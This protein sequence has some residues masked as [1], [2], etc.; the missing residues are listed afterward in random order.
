MSG[1]KKSMIL[2][3]DVN[4]YRPLLDAV[5]AMATKYEQHISTFKGYVDKPGGTAWEGQTAE[6]SQHNVG[7]GWKVTARIQDLDTKY[8]TTAGLAV[9]HTIVP[10]LSNCQHMI[11]NIEA[12]RNKGLTLSEDLEVGYNPPPGISEQLAA[13]NAKVAKARGEELKESARKWWEAEQEVKRL[14]EGVIRDI[15]NEVNSAAGTFDIGKAVK[16][17]A[18]RKPE[19]TQD[20]NFYKDWYPKKD[21]PASTQAAA[22]TA[23][24]PH[25]PVLGPPLPGDKPPVDPSKLGGLTGNLGVM[26]ITDPKSPLDKPPS[27]PDARTAPAPKLDPN[28]PQGKAAIDKFRGILATQYPPDQVEAKL[29]DA[30]K[31]AQ[32]DRPMVATP[33]P[34]TPER[35]RQSGGEAFAESWDQAGRAKDDLLGINGGDHAKE[36]WKGVAKGLWDV[37]NPDPVHQVEHGI[38]QAKGAIDEVKSGIDNPKA[39]IGKHGIEIAA[40]IATAPLGGEGALLG[41]E[42]RALTH[43]L[44]DAAP[45]H[46]PT[47]HSVE[48]PSSATHA[49]IS[50]HPA[51]ANADHSSVTP[52]ADGPRLDMEGNPLKY[53]NG[54]RPDYG[55]N[56]LIDVWGLSREEQIADIR[57]GK[58]DLPEP[59]P[60][61]QWVRLHPTGPIGD[62]WTVE[63]GHRLIEWQDGDSRTGLWDMGHVGGNEYAK[64]RDQYHDG[65][66]TFRDFIDEYRDP[67]NY[68]VQDPYR[69]RSH[70]DEHR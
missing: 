31:G 26:G 22:A 38:D 6:A 23:V 30:I 48:P 5:H 47:P 7:D 42:G 67:E 32:Q 25:A 44:D 54:N 1:P 59:G 27:P 53:L 4:S 68:R 35:V 60:D 49:P 14:T 16:D 15:E 9:D 52:D 41:T 63:N 61:Q 39:F 29:S 2:G 17:A 45:G 43:G 50:D 55:P 36:A 46:A 21:D 62:D 13:E 11:E 69:N 10:E 64:L 28:T 20:A 12:Q 57:G 19:G 40:G 66:I 34:G 24:D 56:Q 58:L 18:P 33:E 70:I 3:I 51:P 8:Q 37:A 65:L